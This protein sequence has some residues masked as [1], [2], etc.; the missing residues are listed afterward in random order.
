MLYPINMPTLQISSQFPLPKAK[1]A[2][3]ILKFKACSKEGKVHYLP[4]CVGYE[5]YHVS[6]TDKSLG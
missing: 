5:E 4:D 2:L 1:M 3:E 6:H